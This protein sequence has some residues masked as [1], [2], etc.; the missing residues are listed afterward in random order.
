MK[1]EINIKN[2]GNYKGT[3]GWLCENADTIVIGETRSGDQGA[4]IKDSEGKVI[5]VLAVRNFYGGADNE[6][7]KVKRDGNEY[8]LTC[9]IPYSDAAWASIQALSEIAEGEMEKS[10]EEGSP[11]EFD[12]KRR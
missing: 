6:I 10:F 7:T 5:T 4:W 8:D 3:V 9:H 11:I 1:K 2:Q 12:L